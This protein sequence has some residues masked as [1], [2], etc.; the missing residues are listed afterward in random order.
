M[1]MTKKTLAIVVAAMLLLSLAIPTVA[2][3]LPGNGMLAGL[4]MARQALGGVIATAQQR[5]AA[6]EARIAAVLQRRKARFDYVGTRLANRISTV[7][8]I[9]DKI[10][11]TGADVSSARSLLDSASQNLS[12]AQSIEAQAVTQFNAVPSAPNKRVAFAA[13]RVTGRN[14]GSELILA[15]ADL[16]SAVVSLRQIV[17]GLRS[18]TATSTPAGV[19]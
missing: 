17:R 15:R 12:N 13:A 6:L 14:A 19:Q 10:A 18:S 9:A 4:G 8:S 16:R 2:L 5:V 1:S 3:A 11:A 7:R